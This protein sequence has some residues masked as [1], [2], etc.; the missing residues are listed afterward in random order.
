VLLVAALAPLA[1]S[2]ADVVLDRVVASVGS[3]AVTES[4]VLAEYRFQQ[5]QRGHPVTGSPDGD[6]FKRILGQLIDRYLIMQDRV[7]EGLPLPAVG[8]AARKELDQIK[9]AY[10][11]PEGYQSAVKA[12]GLDEGSILA[13]LEIE[14]QVLGVIDERLRPSAWV[15]PADIQTYYEKTFV[16]Q[17]EK[18]N[19]KSQP[20]APDAVTDQIREILIQKKIDELLNSWLQELRANR[21]VRIRTF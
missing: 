6:E 11:T 8:E 21:R 12:L 4:E 5:F 16:P 18:L 10:K 3:Y 2:G 19:N 14:K 15:D 13:R 17:Y 9:A 20:P 7:A 1:I